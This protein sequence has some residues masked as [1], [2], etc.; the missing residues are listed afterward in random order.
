MYSKELY[1]SNYSKQGNFLHGPVVRLHIGWQGKAGN[2]VPPCWCKVQRTLV[3]RGVLL[4][5]GFTTNLHIYIYIWEK[6]HSIINN[7]SWTLDGWQL[8]LLCSLAHNNVNMTHLYTCTG[9]HIKSSLQHCLPVVATSPSSWL[10]WAPSRHN[11]DK[12][13]AP[14]ETWYWEQTTISEYTLWQHVCE[15]Q[16]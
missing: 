11:P 9:Q 7:Q 15:Y 5:S 10:H 8:Q 2:K 12:V 13:M 16:V 4:F 1:W 6:G 14:V 3:I